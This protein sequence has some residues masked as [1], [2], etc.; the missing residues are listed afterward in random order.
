MDYENSR[1]FMSAFI[2]IEK[3]LE[4]TVRSTQYIP[5][6]QL[7]DS[8]AQIDPFV[9]DVAIELKEYADLRNAI[10]HERIDGRP[11]AEPHYDVVKRL[12]KIRDLLES[13]PI[14]ADHFLREVITCKL[15]DLLSD[16]V[17]KMLENAFSKLP[18][19][20]G[21]KFVGLLTAEAITYWLADGFIDGEGL[22]KQEKV[23]SVLKY[24]DQPDNNYF[25]APSC[26]LF[27]ILRIFDAYRHKGKRLQAILITSDG[28]KTGTLL[29]I[30]TNFD[31]P[32]IYHIIEGS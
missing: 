30:M 32:L 20:E 8:A 15:T 9:R 5:F 22:L 12:E 28:T 18:V 24:I 7:V 6:Y 27:E 3:V 13:P 16:A 1:R 11:I 21:P 26:S 14:V 23:A 25:V 17:S 29:G 10:V 19:Y 2:D 4:K 31:L